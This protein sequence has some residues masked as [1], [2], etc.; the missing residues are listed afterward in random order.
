MTSWEEEGRNEPTSSRHKT[1]RAARY[2]IHGACG[3]RHMPASGGTGCTRASLTF[4]AEPRTT[5]ARVN[6]LGLV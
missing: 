5:P 1:K 2:V 4:E 6:D 3:M